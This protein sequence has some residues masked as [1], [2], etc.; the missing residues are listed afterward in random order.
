MSVD[1][2]PLSWPIG[3]TRTPAATR[4]RA[5]FGKTETVLAGEN[6]IKTRKRLTT[7]DAALRLHREIERL[8]GHDVILSTNLRLRLDGVP[9]SDQGDPADPGAAVYFELKK[10]P[11]CLACDRWTRVADNVA[12]LAAHIDALRRIERYG[13]G[14]IEQAFRGYLALPAPAG[15]EWWR[16]LDLAPDATLDDVEDAFRRKARE[17]HPDRGGNVDTMARLTEAREA[18]R[19]ALRIQ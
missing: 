6:R 18:A 13:V 7:A 5:D 2:Y 11:I 3:W 1:R 16:I 8:G 19:R 10:Q 14:K 4:R 12:A 15:V 9:R 17:H